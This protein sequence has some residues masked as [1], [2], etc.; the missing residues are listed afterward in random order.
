MNAESF[1]KHG[2]IIGRLR[3]SLYE[4]FPESLA[5][6][7][8][9]KKIND[10]GHTAL[11]YSCTNIGSMEQVNFFLENGSDI[12]AQNAVSVSIFLSLYI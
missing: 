9:D 3:Q 5:T 12:N 10:E 8:I 11:T 7:R 6:D 2:T 1:L 4:K